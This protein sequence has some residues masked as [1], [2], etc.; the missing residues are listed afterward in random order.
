LDW[1]LAVVVIGIY[2]VAVLPMSSIGRRLRPV[3]KR[4]HTEGGDMTSRLAELL[5]GGRLVKAFRLEDYATQPRNGRLEQTFRLQMKAG[6][7]RGRTGPALE[8]LAG[9]VIAG[10]IAFAYWRI[11]AGISTVGDFM[12]FVTA[13]LLASQPI[14]SLGSVATS[15]Q[16]GLAAAERIYELIDE[17]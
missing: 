15:A 13:L 3:A 7:V 17:R 1:M 9:L 5:A 8:T 10:V 6:R 2:P 11:A 14:K 16:E 4:T 12:G